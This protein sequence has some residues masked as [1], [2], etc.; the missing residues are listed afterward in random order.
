MIGIDYNHIQTMLY[1]VSPRP[2]LKMNVFVKFIAHAPV[3]CLSFFGSVV[4]MRPRVIYFFKVIANDGTLFER[5]GL[6]P[7]C[8]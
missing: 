4:T 7:S 2:F 6:L 5:I 3:L 8:D 1:T